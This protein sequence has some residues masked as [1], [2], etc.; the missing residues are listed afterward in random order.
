MLKMPST[1]ATK[2][3][4]P[5]MSFPFGVLWMFSL[6]IHRTLIYAE[7]DCSS[8][9]LIIHI[10]QLHRFCRLHLSAARILARFFRR[11]IHHLT[12]YEYQWVCKSNIFPRNRFLWAAYFPGDR[13]LKAFG[14]TQTLEA[15]ESHTKN[16][17]STWIVR[18]WWVFDYSAAATVTIQQHCNLFHFITFPCQGFRGNVWMHFYALECEC[19]SSARLRVK[20]SQP[21][22]AILWAFGPTLIRTNRQPFFN[23]HHS[24]ITPLWIYPGG[25]LRANH[26]FQ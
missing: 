1:D 14:Q 20:P 16:E 13:W 24:L 9:R 17:Y 23:Q 3:S 21:N 8:I 15:H 19:T 25:Y 4:P 22:R 18:T 2:D 6:S 26:S 7:Y 10:T 12:A 11:K 5:K